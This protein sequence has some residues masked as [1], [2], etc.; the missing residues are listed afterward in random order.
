MIQNKYLTV[1]TDKILKELFQPI[2]N[3]ISN[4][5]IKPTGGIWCTSFDPKLPNYNSWVDYL[6]ENPHLLV[7]KNH[8]SSPF[9]QP[10]LMI[11]LKD[12]TQIFTLDSLEKLEILKKN[13]K[14]EFGYIDYEAISKN[15][16][17][18]YIDLKSLLPKLP[19][20]E[21][22]MF[23]KFV[24]S[25]L[26]IFNLHCIDYYQP[27]QVIIEPFELEYSHLY[28][29]KS[30][31]IKT[32]E[33]KLKVLSMDECTKKEIDNL[34][35]RIALI[36]EQKNISINTTNT[37]QLLLYIKTLVLEQTAGEYPVLCYQ[38]TS[39]EI[40]T[41]NDITRIIMKKLVKEK[42]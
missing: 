19:R 33:Q 28:W 4:N 15:F 21:Q 41:I 20:E 12:T 42:N 16:D 10:S 25:T 8:F 2:K 31:Q 3:P 22:I 7:H 36:M 38:N 6:L 32:E 34:K 27:S 23:K 1:G 30:Y 13:Y 11:T 14:L 9:I 24:V 39:N 35:N 17:A 18:I 29:D 5:E 26:L 40:P 37:K